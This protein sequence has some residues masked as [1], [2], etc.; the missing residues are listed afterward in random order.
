MITMFSFKETFKL[1]IKKEII[2]LE[3]HHLVTI[4]G[5]G[6]DHQWLLILQKKRE[7]RHYMPVHKSAAQYF[8]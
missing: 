5:L 3:Y 1:Y 7:T 6:N 8:L 2:K 4:N